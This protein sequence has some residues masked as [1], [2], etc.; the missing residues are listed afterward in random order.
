MRLAAACPALA[1]ALPGM[2]W[3]AGGV[4]LGAAPERGVPL[5]AKRTI[6]GFGKT[7]NPRARS[8]GSE[9]TRKVE[10]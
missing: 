3:A 8:R 1:L 4:V 5:A 7:M 2:A 9:P 6:S 10:R